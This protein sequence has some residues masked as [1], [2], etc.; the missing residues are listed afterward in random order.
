MSAFAVTMIYFIAYL[1]FF[2]IDSSE[3]SSWVTEPSRN[4]GPL[5]SGISFQQSFKDFALLNAVSSVV[6]EIVN[7]IPSIVLLITLLIFRI[8][9]KSNEHTIWH[10]KYTYDVKELEDQESL[11]LKLIARRQT[12]IEA[13]ERM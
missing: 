5:K 13:Y 1:L 2:L 4:C 9:M 11:L 6:Y 8:I 7:Y 12:K 10:N 3:H